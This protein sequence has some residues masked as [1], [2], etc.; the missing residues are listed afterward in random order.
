[1]RDTRVLGTHC[2]C[3]A[4][5]EKKKKQK[6]KL[7]IKD[8]THIFFLLFL[9]G[10]ETRGGQG[11]GEG[12]ADVRRTEGERKDAVEGDVCVSE[13][14]RCTRRGLVDFRGHLRF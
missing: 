14:Q 13:A 6:E 4:Q 9:S 2:G 5:D 1:M 3:M 8:F 7:I 10:S 11:R 12:T